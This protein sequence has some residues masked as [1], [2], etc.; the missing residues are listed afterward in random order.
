V[1]IAYDLT[2]PPGQRVVIAGI[3]VGGHPLVDEFQTQF[4]ASA[5]SGLD[6]TVRP[7]LL[8]CYDAVHSLE[9]AVPPASLAAK[10]AADR[11][12]EAGV[13]TVWGG[14]LQVNR[15]SEA[16]EYTLWVVARC[17][18]WEQTAPAG[19]RYIHK[20]APYFFG[21]IGALRCRNVDVAMMLFEA[22]DLADEATYLRAGL[23]TTGA[24]FP[25]RT[26]LSLDPHSASLMGNDVVRLRSNL[27][28]WLDAFNAKSG[29]PATEPLTEADLDTALF[30]RAGFTTEA[31]QVLGYLLRTVVVDSEPVLKV[32]QGA[33]PLARRR[34]VEWLF[35]LLTAVERYVRAAAGPGFDRGWYSQSVA[36]V[37]RRNWSGA[38]PAAGGFVENMDRV[39]KTFG[40]DLDKC[41]DY[42]ASAAPGTDFAGAPWF[43]RWLETGRFIRNSAAHALTTHVA[44]GKRWP[45]TEEPVR[46]ALLSSIWLGLP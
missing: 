35:G 8:E 22:G 10:D 30:Q 26:F 31:R 17:F 23:P 16:V 40:D 4:K 46:F 19:K 32:V 24:R 21:G 29:V 25:G 28:D 15:N 13:S 39:A 34:Q 42:W 27:K 9:A 18:E 11:I 38:A 44:V 14:L 7:L 36:E 20:G 41:I 45:D 43:L 33:G 12:H 3:A 6:S 37:A 1:T 2:Q 5:S